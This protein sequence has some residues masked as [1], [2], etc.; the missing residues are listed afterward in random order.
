MTEEILKLMGTVREGMREN[1]VHKTYDLW[2]I[3]ATILYY[4]VLEVHTHVQ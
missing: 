1:S 4:L 3:Y 2:H